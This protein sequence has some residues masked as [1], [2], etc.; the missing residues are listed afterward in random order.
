MGTIHR[1]VGKRIEITLNTTNVIRGRLVT[2]MEAVL[3]GNRIAV[4]MPISGGKFVRLPLQGGYLVKIFSDR[5]VL[6]YDAAVAGHKSENDMHY[7]LFDLIGEGER[8]QVRSYYRQDVSIPFHFTIAGH[9][10]GN[11]NP[12]TCYGIINDLSGGGMRFTSLVEMNAPIE[13]T[14][15]LDLEKKPLNVLGDVLERD[16]LPGGNQKY[17]YRV[18]FKDIPDADKERIM[19]YVNDQQYKELRMH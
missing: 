6:S 4:R 17:R 1:N 7:T 9:V 5:E 2:M 12:I 18:R 13:I 14:A 3:P 11:N 10:D 15:V 16:L 19:K 8:I